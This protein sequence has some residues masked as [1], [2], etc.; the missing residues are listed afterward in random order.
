MVEIKYEFEHL[1]EFTC[2][3]GRK[4]ISVYNPEECHNFFHLDGS[5]VKIGDRLYKVKGVERFCHSPPWRKGEMIG[6]LVEDVT[7]VE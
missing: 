1:G 2:S 7:H 3:R 4:T 6:L 5:I